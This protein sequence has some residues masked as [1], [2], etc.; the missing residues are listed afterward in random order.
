M[1]KD[2]NNDKITQKNNLNSSISNSRPVSKKESKI[3]QMTSYQEKVLEDVTKSKANKKAIII[4]VVLIILIIL[5]CVGVGL[6]FVLR[7]KEDPQVDV[8]CKV[9]VITYQ[10]ATDI[11]PEEY[12]VV[13]AAGEFD[14]TKDS[15]NTAN[16]TQNVE[17]QIKRYIDVAL[18]YVVENET[19]NSYSYTFD[20]GNMEIKNC[21]IVVK[22]NKDS[23]QFVINETERRFT[24][25]HNKDIVLEI[26]VSVD[27]LSIATND[28]TKC[29][30][31]IVLTLQ[32][33]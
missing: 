29:E 26:R 15:Q 18:Q 5:S 20:F 16:H 13:G 27:D 23:Q 31:G 10:I 14:F 2:K 4:S 9:N 19:G 8:V 33:N 12:M 7:P 11:Y 1:K 28:N 3:K 6:F 24:I 17:T 32:A 22:T 25:S 21:K 30:G